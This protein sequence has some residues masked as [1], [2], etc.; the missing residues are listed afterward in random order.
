VQLHGS[1]Q[2][3]ISF[4]STRAPSTSNCLIV[5]VTSEPHKRWHSAPS[6][7][8]SSKKQTRRILR[9]LRHQH[10]IT[11]STAYCV[12]GI[13]FCALQLNYFILVSCPSPGPRTKSWRRHWQ[14]LASVL[15]LQ[16]LLLSV[17]VDVVCCCPSV[18]GRLCE[19]QWECVYQWDYWGGGMSAGCRQ[20]VQLFAGAGNG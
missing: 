11:V 4:R 9:I 5:Q 13:I 16:L 10:R 19:C 12:N 14:M 6:S 20:R 1:T 15:Q 8:L 3:Q 17:A 2:W 18:C 7:F